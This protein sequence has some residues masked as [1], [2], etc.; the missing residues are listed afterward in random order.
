MDYAAIEIA[1]ARS[2]I[3][4]DKPI[5]PRSSRRERKRSRKERDLRLIAKSDSPQRGHRRAA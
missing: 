3:A 4:I 1:R 5:A 2:E